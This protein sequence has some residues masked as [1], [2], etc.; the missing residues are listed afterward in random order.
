VGPRFVV[1]GRVAPTERAIVAVNSGEVA[2]EVKL[3][4]GG[5]MEV[6]TGQ[7]G[8]QV[9]P[10]EVRVWIARGDFAAEAKSAET[11]WRTGAQ[12]RRVV[13][14]LPVGAK[15]TGSGPELGFWTPGA[16]VGE[17]SLPV[18]AVFEF[19]VVR[20]KEWEQHDNRV[21]FV[22][23]AEGPLEVKVE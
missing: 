16:A 5:W 21:L 10:G 17:A 11:Q 13:F 15:V 12:K 6:L 23:A 3:P 19:K 9:A 7:A 22:P 1:L 8:T 4:A 18:G 20:G 14:K 2:R